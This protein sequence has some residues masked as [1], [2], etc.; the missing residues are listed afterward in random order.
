[1]RRISLRYGP[2]GRFGRLLAKIGLAAS[3]AQPILKS[4]ITLAAV[5]NVGAGEDDLITTS[6][7]AAALSEAGKGVRITAWGTTA[8]NANAKT[9]KVY[10]GTQVV[11]TNSLTAS[12]AGVWKSETL[13]FSTGTDTQD[14]VS[15][16][17]TLGAAGVAL[18]D[19]EV[20]TATQDDGAAIT[21]KATGEAVDNNDIVQEGLLVE[22]FN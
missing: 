10:F 17:A 9:L 16:L 15:R 2:I 20:G 14:W 3:E 8:N 11:L 4:S 1:M 18:N 22:F 7:P 21:I 5:A 19:V 12:I 13:V 6:I